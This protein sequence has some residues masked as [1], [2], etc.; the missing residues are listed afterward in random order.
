MWLVAIVLDNAGLEKLF[1]NS[2][3]VKNSAKNK[4]FGV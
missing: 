4:N 3:L 2:M 1:Y